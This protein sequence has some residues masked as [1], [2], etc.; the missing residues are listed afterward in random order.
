MKARLCNVK[1]VGVAGA[2]GCC[3]PDR[4]DRSPAA[5]C[6]GEIPRKEVAVG[7]QVRVARDMV[8]VVGSPAIGYENVPRRELQTSRRVVD[9]KTANIF[10]TYLRRLSHE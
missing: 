3:A 1:Y 6:F 4:G 9:L 2:G 8:P 5:M 7:L 10:Q